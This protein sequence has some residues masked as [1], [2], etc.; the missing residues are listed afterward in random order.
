M[1]RRPGAGPGQSWG[2]G[3]HAR[4][5]GG[6]LRSLPRPRPRLRGA[7][8]R[9]RL[10]DDRRGEGL[11]AHERGRRHPAARRSRLRVVERVPARRGAGGRR[12]RVSPGHRPGRDLRRAAL[13]RDGGRHRQRGPRQAPPVRAAG[14]ARALPGPHLLVAEHQ[15]LPGPALG[16]RAGDLRR[17]PVPDRPP[18][19]RLRAGS[20]GRRP[21][22]LPGHRHRQALRRPQRS[23]AGPAP[24]RRAARPSATSTRPTCPRSGCSSRRARSRR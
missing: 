14:Q 15:H 19:R 17:G 16:A 5:E 6:C 13:P 20:A 22:L 10:P 11:A 12:D 3:V 9:P 23:R 8:R 1:C 24:L 21:A 18:G 7:G 2:D 4:A